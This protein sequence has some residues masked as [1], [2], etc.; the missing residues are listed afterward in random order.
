MEPVP[1]DEQI[2]A[3]AKFVLENVDA[4]GLHKKAL[5]SKAGEIAKELADLDLDAE[6]IFS[7][8]D[9][10]VGMAGCFAKDSQVLH[11][12]MASQLL[13]L[14]KPIEERLLPPEGA[15]D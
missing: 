11:P 1:S 14:L 8:G 7:M 6:D 5:R 13:C 4:V 3:K 12:E 9:F 10:A 15:A 2:Y